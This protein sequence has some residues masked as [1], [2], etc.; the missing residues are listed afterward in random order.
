MKKAPNLETTEF[1]GLLDKIND[2]I[3]NKLYDI[4]DWP[5]ACIV[6][7]KNDRVVITLVAQTNARNYGSDFKLWA[8]AHTEPRIRLEAAKFK[9]QSAESGYTEKEIEEW[10][11]M[12]DV[13]E[14]ES[15]SVRS[16]NNIVPSTAG[17]N[18]RIIYLLFNPVSY[19][20][21]ADP[22]MLKFVSTTPTVVINMFPID[23][24]WRIYGK[25][26]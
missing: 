14:N 9:I 23:V 18:D 2:F 16:W 24:Y 25:A 21:A 8:L 4:N 10:W 15:C 7:L 11:D 17:S 3:V 19:L 20:I 13:F 1:P 26:C 6:K 12:I 22:V 5:E